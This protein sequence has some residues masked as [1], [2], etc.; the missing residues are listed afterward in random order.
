MERSSRK[1]LVGTV[2]STK[3]EKTISVQVDSYVTHPLYGKRFKSS[4]KF[5]A[6]D[7]NHVAKT[8]D[9]VQISET[10]PYSK[11]KTFRLVKVLQQAKESE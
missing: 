2:V 5:L 1:L 11:N 8:G 7:E 3:M 4:K 9:I 6:H 10:K